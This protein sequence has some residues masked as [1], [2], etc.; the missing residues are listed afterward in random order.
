MADDDL[1]PVTDDLFGAPTM[2][3][4]AEG[5]NLAGRYVL[6]RILGRGGMGVIWLAR[7]QKLE[8]DVALKFLPDVVSLD[9][10]AISDLKRETRRSLELTHPNIVRIYDFVEDLSWAGISMEYVA[11]DTFSALKVAQPN[12]CFEVTQLEAWV[13]QLC[14]ALAYAHEEAHIVHRDL[15]PAN[16][17]VDGKGRLKITDFGIARSISDSVSRVSIRGNSSGTLAY[18]SPQQARGQAPGVSDDVY[19][20]GATLYD[21]IAGKPPFYTG[22]IYQQLLYENPEPM[23]QRRVQLGIKGGAIPERWEQAIASCLAKDPAHRPQSA[24]E[25]AERLGLQVPSSSSPPTVRLPQPGAVPPPPE[26]PPQPPSGNRMPLFIGA[27]ILGLLILGALGYYFGV[28]LPADRAQEAA[29]ASQ[30]DEQ[31]K[32]EAEAQNETAAAE[33]AQHDADAKK[34]EAA[35][36]AEQLQQQQKDQQAAAAAAEAA[37]IANARGGLT[38]NTDPAGAQVTFGSEAPQT[39]PATFKDIKL[40]TYPLH[41]T[42]DG[43]EPVDQTV[44]IKENQVN[45]LGTITLE[46]SKGTIQITSDPPGLPYTLSQNGVITNS[47]TTPATVADLLVGSYDISVKRGYREVKSTVNVQRNGTTAY[48]P[49]FPATLNNTS[50]VG[51]SAYPSYPQARPSIEWTIA[52]LIQE[53]NSI[54]GKVTEPRTDFGPNQAYLTSSISGSIDGDS[55]SFT[56][57][58]DYDGHQVIYKGTYDPDEGSIKGRWHIKDFYGTFRMHITSSP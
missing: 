10:E 52:N 41:I 14:A 56:K 6:L 36:Q 28:K 29:L 44:E 3:G 16:L 48:T 26:L 45:D 7:D 30:V 18:M 34:A 12:R 54:Q 9:K 4:F 19:S 33:K 49:Q 42:L 39:S 51:T 46:R 25:I 57:T 22:E 20:A 23:A 55:V 53:G 5:Q 43:Y 13:R 21:L 2:R 32:K 1:I 11:G 50:W 35:A 27:A 47:G 17:M 8:R 58:Y 15:K 24:T 38:L 37:R 31:K 40:G